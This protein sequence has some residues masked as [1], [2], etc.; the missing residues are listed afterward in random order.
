MGSFSLRSK[1][2]LKKVL[3]G[4]RVFEEKIID[5]FFKNTFALIDIIRASFARS[6]KEPVIKRNGEQSLRFCYFRRWCE[7]FSCYKIVNITSVSLHCL[8]NLDISC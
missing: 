6:E 5:F 8:N 4:E 2:A 7:D 3:W 1:I